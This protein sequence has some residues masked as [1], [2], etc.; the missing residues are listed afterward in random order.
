M[1]KILIKNIDIVDPIDGI[2]E[3]F[4]ILIEDEYIK[5]VDRNIK[6]DDTEIIDGKDKFAF[7]GFID[8]HTHLREP[9]FEDRE[10]LESGSLAG[11][12][13]GFVALCCM[14][15]TN[16]PLDN[17]GL[18]KYIKERSKYIG[19]L[20]IY[21]VGTITKE[22][23]GEVLSE[24]GDMV[25]AGAVA[26]SDD[27]NWVTNSL[28]MRSALEYSLIFD[29]PVISHCEDEFL[30]KNG[31]AHENSETIVKGLLGRPREAEIIA[32]FRDITLA[33]K[34]GGRL[35]IAHISTKEGIELIKKAKEE[36]V[37]VTCEA[38]PHHIS[39]TYEKV[40]DY[41][42]NA[43]T[44]PPLREEEDRIR[45]IEGIKEGIVDFLA[46]DHAPHLKFDKEKEFEIAP[47]GISG[48]ETAFSIYYETLVLKNNLSL[49]NLSFLLSYNP[50]KFLK[51]EKVG[52][53]KE[54]YY[55]SLTIVDLNKK[56]ICDPNNFFS[57][58]KNTPFKGKEMIGKVL[59][60]FVKGKMF[61]FEYEKGGG[62]ERK[63]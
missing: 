19:I 12:H 37:N 15:N 25:E 39:L 45:I 4:D 31:I 53:I 46:T 16:P 33:K 34:I 35:H 18:I 50:A 21:P 58:G 42:P 7:P 36:G 48:L 5:G 10:D 23:K 47:P 52:R 40:L 49:K 54:G 9:G 28:L 22:R 44:N 43:K 29:I 27:G 32:I 62:N 14:P 57:K 3:N 38:T 11:V 13:G 6:V 55:A 61:C 51:I 1:G 56:W 20:D 59:Y 17:A 60:T 63:D 2:R 8:I 26:I 24:I 41:D 30:V